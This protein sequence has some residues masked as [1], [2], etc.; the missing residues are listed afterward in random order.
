MKPKSDCEDPV[1][2][3]VRSPATS[4]L[5]DALARQRVL[6]VLRNRSA[7]DAVA[8][9]RACAAEGMEVVELTTSTPDVLD[10]VRTLAGDGLIVGVGTLRSAAE[11]DGV[12]AAGAQFAVSYFLPEGFVE[13]AG[14][15][16][17][18]A[19]PGAVTPNEMQA[20]VTAGTRVLKIF[21]AYLADPR[22]IDD[23]RPLL[24]PVSYLVT[25]GLNA[26]TIP[27]WLAAGAVAAGVGRD[28][29]T[30]AEDGVDGV[31]SRTRALLDAVARA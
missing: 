4:P 8:T 23:M 6:P 12:A 19:I 14:E 10:A 2:D 30:V 21:P 29:G 11:L 7:A 27:T 16:G 13:R 5:L 9:A 22:V 15:L 20:A 17:L 18:V 1:H 24:G 28:V 26:E 3:D 31:R 25:G